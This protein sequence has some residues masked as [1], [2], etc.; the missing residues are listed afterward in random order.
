MNKQAQ[1]YLLNLVKKNYEDVAEEF[2]ITRQK[3]PWQGLVEL[4]QMVEDENSVLDVGCGNGRLVRLFGGKTINYIGVDSSASLIELAKTNFPDHSF[5]VSNILELGQI[6]QI[7]FDFIFC[8]AVLHHLPGADLQIAALKKLKNKINFDGKIIISVWNMWE[9][10]KYR[11]LIIKY[12]LLKL[13]GK[14]KMDLGDI[15]FSW[16][17]SLGKKLSERYYHAFTMVQL[18][19]IAKQAGLKIEKLYKDKYN[20]YLILKK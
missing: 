5:N 18:K 11:N 17:N 12:F 4:T 7:N 1:K 20:Y 19:K 8:I 9:Q 6:K 2:D 13:I 16:K 10:K 3:E 15:I 14:N